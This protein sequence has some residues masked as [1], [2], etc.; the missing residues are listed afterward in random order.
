[1]SF[2]KQIKTTTN[3][4]HQGK[5]GRTPH[6][7]LGDGIAVVFALIFFLTSVG[8]EKLDP[9]N[10]AWLTF[11][12][13][14]AQLLGWWFF[15]D[16]RWRWPLGANPNYG[17]EQTNSIVFTDSIP[18]LAVIFKAL[19]LSAFDSGQY[20]GVSL[21]LGSIAV[22]V[23][24][25]KLLSRLGLNS[26]S[27]LFGSAL[28]GTTPIFWWMQRWYVALSTG[29]ALLVWATFFYFD[30]DVP[31]RRVWKRWTVLLLL[32]ISVQAYLLI[33]IIGVLI[34]ALTRRLI[35]KK[36]NFRS[37]LTYFSV[38]GV[39]C[40]ATMYI[41]GY[42]TVQS[43]WAQTGGYG[44]YSANTLGFI[45]SNGASRV[46]PNL[47]STSGQYEPTSL[48]TG[49]LLLLILLGIQRLT[50]KTKFPFREWTSRHFV[51]LIILTVLLALAI[52]NTVSIGSWSFRI[53]IPSRV[54]HGLS[55]FR[56]SARFVW[57]SVV[58]MTTV[59][60]VLASRYLRYATSILGVVA[61]MQVLDYSREL[62]AV[63]AQPDGRK[64][65]FRFDEEFWSKVP[66]RYEVIAAHP[67]ASLGHGWA[68][69]AYAA[70]QTGRVAQCGYFGRVQGLEAVNRIN[71]DAFFTGGLDDRT[72]YWIPI[73]WIQSHRTRL[74]VVYPKSRTDTAVF[75]LDSL[76][77]S[78]VLVF[79]GCSLDH[80][81]F[82][83]QSKEFLGQFLRGSQLDP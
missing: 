10:L 47:P 61:L 37:I 7:V 53:P 21:L 45:D 44:W 19:N 16:D 5:P 3:E 9:R 12:D 11:G 52:T 64:I 82:L 68:E 54:E 58:I 73:E 71:S 4:R 33:P 48:A 28:L 38:T 46:L 31:L 74:S 36:D 6:T 27:A 65:D 57:P 30:N 14:R 41:F 23:G 79:P 25:R 20:F 62:V 40:V 67:A 83:G 35:L 76:G 17:W 22:F 77:D 55:I 49:T 78:T 80:C 56:S 18:G 60:I 29:V 69:C 43:K 8:F 2:A 34:A 59:I 63:A 50:S 51:L 42:F 39:S 72:I 32:V 70:V 75:R 66:S 26:W 81:S 1:M 24:A 15:A 13:Q